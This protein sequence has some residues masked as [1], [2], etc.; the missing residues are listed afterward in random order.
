[1]R[2]RFLFLLCLLASLGVST[3]PVEAAPMIRINPVWR[4][5]TQL[6]SIDADGDGQTDAGDDI[7][8]VAVDIYATVNVEFW[9]IGMVCTVNK[10]VLESYTLFGDPVGSG[11]NTQIFTE[12][13]DWPGVASI[14]K[15]SINTIDT[16]GKINF[17]I[18]LSGETTPP[19]GSNGV[20]RTLHLVSLQYRVREDLSSAGSSPFTCT[21]S[22]VNRS[23]RRVL[24][25]QFI[26]PPALRIFPGYTLTGNVKYQGIL[27]P[28]TA[29]Q[30]IQV[31]CDDADGDSTFDDIVTTANLST[32]NF[33]ASNLRNQGRY[34]C[35]FTPTILN[36][37]VS[38]DAIHL[39]G[40]TDFN[41]T[42]PSYALLPILLK[43]GNV[44]TATSGSSNDIDNADLLMVTSNWY[45]PSSLL[46]AP[47]MFG[48]ATG[49]KKINEM[50]LAVV[51]GNFSRFD[52]YSTQHII[53]SLARDN[54]Q[55]FNS[56]IWSG[57]LN[58]A[59]LQAFGGATTRDY[60]PAV[61][62]NG[63]QIAF[64][65]NLGT[66]GT[67]NYVLFT[68]AISN[69]VIGTAR[70][71]GSTNAGFDAFAPAW[72]PDGSQ[73]AFVCSYN[74]AWANISAPMG[75]LCLVDAQGQNLRR[76][77]DFGGAFFRSKLQVPA[78]I[79]EDNLYFAYA[80]DPASPSPCD[81]SLCRLNVPSLAINHPSSLPVGADMPYV[82]NTSMGLTLFYRYDNGAGS[83]NIRFAQLET[84]NFSPLMAYPS[85][86]SGF[87]HW[88]VQGQ[89]FPSGA[90]ISTNV[91]YY[92][93]ST[94]SDPDILYY[95]H[96]LSTSDSGGRTIFFR[97]FS[98]T[99]TS[100]SWIVSG[101]NSVTLGDAI[102]NPAFASGY[103]EAIPNTI[104][105]LP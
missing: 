90:D 14:A 5:A 52:A 12:G 16:D 105:F 19:M 24:T 49:D 70:P 39:L 50:D 26:A 29:A 23:G 80:Q 22:F 1:M 82:R 103:N 3:L 34:D 53:Y 36:N 94:A 47:Y 83:L 79:N 11:D 48:D 71:I 15:H 58:N 99:S 35:R 91:A 77:V 86:S 62:P 27:P 2:F 67:D 76:I 72:S 44:D 60:W 13:A 38:P 33:S 18:S 40:V 66:N 104:V 85:V 89:P 75:H 30:A 74:D 101:F 96:N 17:A 84:S 73:I 63:A 68:A 25:A 100:P 92:T 28:L 81:E 98:G 54:N 41:L 59:S 9:A 57:E 88:N 21:S 93:L 31:T 42:T 87:F 97:G 46:S 8:Y 4:P 7:R 45:A 51:T 56:H 69:G 20:E 32:G 43:N 95:E 37:A 78:W 10:G 6:T 65:R 55:A 61:S 64:V 102:S